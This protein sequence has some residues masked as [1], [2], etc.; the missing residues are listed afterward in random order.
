[1]GRA[2]RLWVPSLVFCAAAGCQAGKAPGAEGPKVAPVPQTG[3]EEAAEGPVPDVSPESDASAAVSPL[4]PD[5][6]ASAPAQSSGREAA[7]SDSAGGP[8]DGRR[9]EPKRGLPEIRVRHIGM[10]IGGGPNDG[11]T[12]RPFLRAI[13]ARNERFLGCYRQV[14]RPMAG[15]TYGVDLYVG[16][17]GKSPEVR[18][19]RQRLGDSDF[20]SCMNDAFRSVDFEPPGKPT[21]LSYSLRFD[22]IDPTA[23]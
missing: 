8:L 21:V 17:R 18:G 3:S 16:R 10:H 5:A 23:R 11:E 9:P 1:M 4:P 7:G 19:A 15:G 2:I 22:V 12:K 20:E 6:T 14:D 13:E